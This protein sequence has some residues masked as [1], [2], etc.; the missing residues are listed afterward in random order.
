MRLR[1]GS[2][3]AKAYM[4]RLRAMQ[5]PRGV[6][7]GKY[8]HSTRSHKPFRSGGFQSLGSGVFTAGKPD[9][10]QI[11]RGRRMVARLARGRRN[12]A[13]PAV[14]ESRTLDAIRDLLYRANRAR[15]FN[16]SR[17]MVSEAIGLATLLRDQAS[18]GIH[19]NPTLALVGA[20]PRGGRYL[21]DAREI[22]YVRAVG[23]HRGQRFKHGF[24]GR[25]KLY[26]MP[27]G[28]IRVVGA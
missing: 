12:P 4:A 18:Q 1:K 7:R 6:R 15:S 19:E 14:S 28:S 8:R 21:G 22:R 17:R 10:R 20:N 11:R 3:A 24:K 27:D 25:T 2:R 23:R 9:K 26:A 5:N 16:Q 13:V